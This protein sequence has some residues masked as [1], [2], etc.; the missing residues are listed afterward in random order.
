MNLRDTLRNGLN[1]PQALPPELRARLLS[2]VEAL[3]NGGEIT[4]KVDKASRY[5]ASIWFLFQMHGLYVDVQSD[6]LKATTPPRPPLH[7]QEEVTR[8]LQ[9]VCSDQTQLILPES[10]DPGYGAMDVALWLRSEGLCAFFLRDKRLEVSW[11]EHPDFFM[12]E[13]CHGTR[14][15]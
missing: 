14:S 3:K 12:T 2:I 7:I 4:V 13:Q 10:S 8:S 5:K 1:H 11:G 9:A 6:V 15:L